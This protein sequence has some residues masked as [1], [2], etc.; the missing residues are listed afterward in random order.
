MKGKKFDNPNL[1]LHRFKLI[2][3]LVQVTEEKYINLYQETSTERLEQLSNYYI[4]EQ[5]KDNLKER[6]K[7]LNRNLFGYNMGDKTMIELQIREIEKELDSL[8]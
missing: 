5:H 7:Y 6:L 1:M 2:D 8:C 3:Y 4:D